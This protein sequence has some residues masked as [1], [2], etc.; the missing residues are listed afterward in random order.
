M[1]EKVVNKSKKSSKGT[2]WD[3]KIDKRLAE[4]KA[5]AKKNGNNF[6]FILTAEDLKPKKGMQGTKV[7]GML[8]S[9]MFSVTRA[10]ETF[11]GS[12][13]EEAVKMVMMK[14]A[15]GDLGSILS[16]ELTKSK[17]NG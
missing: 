4:I 16:G 2:V 7:E 12:V 8:V 17:K 5:Q 1:I 10:V 9:H 13:P 14:K 3:A 11:L 6:V 15:L